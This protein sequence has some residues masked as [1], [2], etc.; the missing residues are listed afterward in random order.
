MSSVKHVLLVISIQIECHLASRVDAKNLIGMVEVDHLLKH[1]TN[2]TIA[3]GAC[4]DIPE[5]DL[6]IKG[7]EIDSGGD[8][9]VSLVKRVGGT[10]CK[11]EE[12]ATKQ[13]YV[14]KE[15]IENKSK[16]ADERLESEQKLE[17]EVRFMTLAAETMQRHKCQGVLTMEER[18]PCMSNRQRS[19]GFV[20]PQMIATL[21]KWYGTADRATKKRCRRTIANEL[22]AAL[23]CLQRSKFVHGDFKGDN[24]L[25]QSLSEDG[26]PQKLTISDFGLSEPIGKQVQK[27]SNEYLRF[28]GHL[29]SAVFKVVAKRG[30]HPQVVLPHDPLEITDRYSERYPVHP[31]IDWCSF[32]FEMANLMPLGEN[33]EDFTS[34]M[35][36][37]PGG[38]DA[39][40][41]KV[42]VPFPPSYAGLDCGW[43][44]NERNI[45]IKFP[46]R[47]PK[48]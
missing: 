28:S 2:Q 46:P 5:Q 37:N 7:D 35:A 33:A 8:G 22:S 12:L 1:S 29:I 23:F 48:K 16:Q 38:E 36:H 9:A 21:W 25:Y 24:V 39:K 19:A 42:F 3:G 44:G 27:K 43:M 30:I 41:W 13:C 47:K 18:H 20:L 11:E 6:W 31:L 17:K 10:W 4:D 34:E 14:L 15:T 26:C 32:M 40:W 45:R